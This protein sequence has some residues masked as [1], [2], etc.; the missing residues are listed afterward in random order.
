MRIRVV[1]VFALVTLFASCSEDVLPK[2]KAQLRL[3]YPEN[4]YQRVTSGCPYVI[5]ISQN[6]QIEFTENCWAQIHYPTLK[7]TMHITYREVEDDLN[8]ILKE[9]EK[10]TYEHTIKADNIPYAIPYEN[11]VKKVFGK[12]MNV[13]GDVASNLQFHVTDSVKNV[14]Y[15]SL[16]FNVKPNYDS[17]LPA[18]KYIEKDIRNL[19]ESVEWKN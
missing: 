13:E 18:I 7:A 12:I 8:A 15:G 11:D 10:L 17:I 6:S 3:E 2:P 1:L 5:E 14:L 16:Y 19:V 9:V 4:S